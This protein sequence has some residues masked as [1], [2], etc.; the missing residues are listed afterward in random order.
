MAR[1]IHKSLLLLGALVA[2]V[3]LAAPAA[4]TTHRHATSVARMSGLETQVLANV[5][6]V[7][8]QHGL[9]PLRLSPSLS[10]AAAQHSRSMADAGYF[11][12]NSA[13]GSAFWRR[14][15]RFYAQGRYGYWSVGENLLWA[16]P[17]VD[18]TGALTMWMASPEHRANL[19]NRNWREIGLSAVHATGAG[20]SF[21]GMDVT[22][23]TAD[24]GTRR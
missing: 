17:D 5:N 18:A 2:A 6:V 21:Q 9:R 15:R 22:I 4:A 13:D 3:S 23:V 16:S 10:A 11:S 20:G 19:L 12:H 8:R 7:R 1:G 14:I 24:F